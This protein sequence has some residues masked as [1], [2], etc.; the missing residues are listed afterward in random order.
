MQ[1]RSSRSHTRYPPDDNELRTVLKVVANEAIRLT[2]L[3]SQRGFEKR[4]LPIQRDLSDVCFFLTRAVRGGR[5]GCA[6][7]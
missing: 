5:D 4:S 6:R 2:F 1:N 7:K 3:I